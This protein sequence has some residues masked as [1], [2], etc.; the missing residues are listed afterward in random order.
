M[1]DRANTTARQWLACPCCD[2]LHRRPTGD[3]AGD[4]HCSACGQK[5]FSHPANAL[6]RTLAF[7]ITGLLLFIPANTYPLIFLDSYGAKD[8]NHLI[9]GPLDLM[10]AS[11][12]GVG[13]LVLLTSIVFPVILLL[14]LAFTAFCAQRGR[15]PTSYRFILRWLQKLYRWAMID[16]YILACLI[17]FI[18]LADLADVTPGPGLY[19]LGG[20]L[21]ATVLASLSFDAKL[22][23]DRYAAHLERSR[24]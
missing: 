4:G 24:S 3:V 1:T 12:P 17:S 16:V 11:M 8:Q 20:A 5:L 21:L 23:W 6:Q 22:L 10:E 14:G 9:S 19:C 2:A 13:L 18:K 15:Y 7:S